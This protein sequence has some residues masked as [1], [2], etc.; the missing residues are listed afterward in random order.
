LAGTFPEADNAQIEK[1]VHVTSK[2]LLLH[3]RVYILL[4]G[5]VGKTVDT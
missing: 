3:A 1:N 2:W 5:N 4:L